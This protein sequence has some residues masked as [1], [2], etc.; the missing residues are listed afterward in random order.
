[1]YGKAYDFAV[2]QYEKASQNREA[3][4]DAL[5]ARGEVVQSV[6]K[7]RLKTLKVPSLKDIKVP[8]LKIEDVKAS[9]KD[10]VQTLKNTV[11]E[12]REKVQSSF[13]QLKEKVIPA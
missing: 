13:E 4:F 9:L 6:A 11:E 8:S 12:T 7:E 1:V 10:N 2:E 3:R 5:V